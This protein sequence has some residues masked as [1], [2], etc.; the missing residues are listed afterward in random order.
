MDTSQ[1]TR[2]MGSMGSTSQMMPAGSIIGRDVKNRQDE[3]LGKIKDVMIDLSNGSIVYAVL[4][5]GGTLGVGDKL[6]AVPWNSLKMPSMAA[7]G[8]AGQGMMGG[9]MERDAF[10]LDVSRSRLEGMQGF[11]KDHWPMSADRSFMVGED[12]SV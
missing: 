6:F 1:Q 9:M 10:V 5:F 8:M 11:D 7:Q 3:S 2:R 12:V 4:S